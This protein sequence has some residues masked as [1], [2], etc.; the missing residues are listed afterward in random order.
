ML[1]FKSCCKY[2]KRSAQITLIKPYCRDMDYCEHFALQSQTEM[3]LLQ[4]KLPH[5]PVPLREQNTNTGSN[6]IINSSYRG[7]MEWEAEIKE[8]ET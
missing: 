8:G 5:Q 6:I 4:K 3:K 2:L 1:K 7:D